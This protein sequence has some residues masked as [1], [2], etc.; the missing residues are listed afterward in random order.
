MKREKNYI[1]KY[2]FIDYLSKNS[3]FNLYLY[4]K[5]LKN[6]YIIES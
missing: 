6:S 2:V 3:N 5:S 1:Y 4:G